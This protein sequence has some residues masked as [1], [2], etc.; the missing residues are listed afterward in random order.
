MTDDGHIEKVNPKARPHV[1]SVDVKFTFHGPDGSREVKGVGTGYSIHEDVLTDLQRLVGMWVA[2]PEEGEP[3]TD[4]MLTT[5]KERT[6]KIV[7]ALMGP[8][9]VRLIDE[10]VAS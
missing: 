7:T 6:N 10:K 2:F 8:M 1:L 5:A 3:R 9:L 4:A